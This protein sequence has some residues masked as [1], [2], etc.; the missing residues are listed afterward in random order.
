[1]GEGW[2]GIVTRLDWSQVDWAANGPWL[3]L[4]LVRAG[5]IGLPAALYALLDRWA[6]SRLR[7]DT[8]A[9]ATRYSMNRQR[10]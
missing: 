6:A 8:I 4:L 9:L 2:A 1:M 10:P 5:G 7:L 3:A